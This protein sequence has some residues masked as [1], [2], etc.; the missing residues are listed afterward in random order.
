MSKRSQ[1]CNELGNARV[2]VL[3]RLY[4]IN[5]DIPGYIRVKSVRYKKMRYV[6]AGVTLRGIEMRVGQLCNFCNR[7]GKV[8]K[9]GHGVVVLNWMDGLDE[10]PIMFRYT[11][12]TKNWMEL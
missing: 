12:V 5:D 6:H 7:A 1:D 8:L 9:F 11:V 10:K 2:F 3:R 4:Y